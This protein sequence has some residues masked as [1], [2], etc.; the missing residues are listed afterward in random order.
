MLSNGRLSALLFPIECVKLAAM[1]KAKT[2]DNGRTY[3]GLS[4]EQ[5]HRQRQQQFLNAGLELFGTVGFRHTTVRNLCKQAKLTDR[6]FYECFG[7][8]ETLLM[9]VYETCMVQLT[10]RV[11]A[12]MRQSYQQQGAAGAMREALDTY[13]KELEDP[14]IARICMVE[15]EGISPE[16]DQLYHSYIRSFG[17]IF[18][19]LADF[20]FP[21]WKA[22]K[23]ER[24]VIG[25]SLVG[26]L[27]QSTT[28]WLI[29]DYTVPRKVMVEG[30]MVL[31]QG[32][33]LHIE[34][35]DSGT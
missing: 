28:H 16:V 14:R 1:S 11:L 2:S 30:S 33:M 25:I 20:A 17:T 23:E 10:K 18:N 3:G 34:S 8:L 7:S 5:R 21:D 26:A 19:A 22:S 6:Y 35:G 4:P 15:L 29:S 31:F 13:F 24:E 32:I 12:S 9:A 27:R